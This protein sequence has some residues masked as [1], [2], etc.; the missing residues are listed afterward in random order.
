MDILTT[1]AQVK[2]YHCKLHTALTSDGA[3]V[4]F[5][6]PHVQSPIIP[7]LKIPIIRGDKGAI[8]LNSDKKFNRKYSL[9]AK[10]HSYITFRFPL[11]L[12][13]SDNSRYEWELL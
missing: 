2:S 8:I 11:I 4:L 13:R 7:D 9:N 3:V 10:K 6:D 1:A 5:S 12:E